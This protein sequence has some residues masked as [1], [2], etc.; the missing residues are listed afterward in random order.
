[1]DWLLVFGS[2]AVGLMF[3]TYWVESRSSWFVLAFSGACAASSAYGWLAS[4]YPFGVIEAF[5]AAVAL[6]R[7]QMRRAT[8]SRPTA[9]ARKEW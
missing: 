2:S 4:V 1:M 5:W 8:E 3:L 9:M 6:R 7:W